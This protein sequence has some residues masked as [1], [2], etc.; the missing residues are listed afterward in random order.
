MGFY[1]INKGH[2]FVGLSNIS[3]HMSSLVSLSPP[4]CQPTSDYLFTWTQCEDNG[5][6]KKHISV[7]E[8]NFLK[9]SV[10]D[11]SR[12]WKQ[13]EVCMSEK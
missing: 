11:V 13:G 8:H 4:N 12:Q 10:N 5:K 7:K 9:W 3:F 2:V 6:I 1:T